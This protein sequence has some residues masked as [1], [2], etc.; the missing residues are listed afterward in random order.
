MKK[1]LSMFLLCFLLVLSSITVFAANAEINFVT[2][3]SDDGEKTYVDVTITENEASMI[4]FCVDYDSE[5]LECVSATAGDVFSGKS[6]PLINKTEGKI[7]FIW[8]SLTALKD[9]GTLLHIEFVRKDK[10]G[11]EVGIDED[12]SFIVANSKFETVGTPGESAK[13][14]GEEEENSSSAT[15]KESSESS[16]SQESSSENSSQES[17]GS[18]SESNEDS[19]SSQSSKPDGSSSASSSSKPEIQTGSNNGI[20][21]DKNDAVIDVEEEIEIEIIEGEKENVVWY[22]SNEDVAKVEDGKVVPVSPGT[23]IIT[24]ATEDG[25]NEATCVITVTEEETKNLEESVEVITSPE[26]KVKNP[27]YLFVIITLL[28]AAVIL[29]AVLIIKKSKKTGLI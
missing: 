23:A 19:S 13:I 11:S 4:Q 22:S 17:S 16:S 5:T 20:T 18:S 29:A 8:D 25:T 7:Y 10:L 14:E 12:E 15:E 28:V 27:A 2:Y 3:E 1:L 26:E 21:V 6:A 24:V 9:S